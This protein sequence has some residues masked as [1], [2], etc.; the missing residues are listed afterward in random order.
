MTLLRDKRSYVRERYLQAQCLRAIYAVTAALALSAGACLSASA[1]PKNIEPKLLSEFLHNGFWAVMQ[2][3]S[4]LVCA[5]DG[6]LGVLTLDTLTT[7]NP[8]YFVIRDFVPLASR[9]LSV[10]YDNFTIVARLADNTY[11]FFSLSAGTKLKELGSVSYPNEIQDYLYQAGNLYFAEEFKG[12]TMYHVD[13]FSDLTFVD[14]SMVGVR[15]T[16]LALSR[17]T[18]YALD[19]YNGIL[20]YAHPESGLKS[21]AGY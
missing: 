1:T 12:L 4:T 2:V 10:R 20:R 8:G 13:G 5:M 14:S 3:D 19:D 17:D 16:Q 9:P 6:G 18:L 7:N 11:K 21:I 15:V